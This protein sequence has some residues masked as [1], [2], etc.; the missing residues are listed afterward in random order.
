[1]RQVQQL[2]GVVTA[3][4]GG[5]RTPFA[6][7]VL[8]CGCAEAVVALHNSTMNVP[9]WVGDMMLANAMG[10]RRTLPLDPKPFPEE[11]TSSHTPTPVPAY[12][13]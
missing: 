1:M 11:C 5:L 8:A 13:G 4:I 7:A 6:W 12:L 9:Q 2:G 10:A 3:Q